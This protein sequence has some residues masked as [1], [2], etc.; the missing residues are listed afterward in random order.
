MLIVS[1]DLARAIYVMAMILY[2]V[3]VTEQSD[4]LLFWAKKW[5]RLFVPCMI[6]GVASCAKMGGQ[7]GEKEDI[8]H[9]YSALIPRFHFVE[10]LP[11]EDRDVVREALL[12]NMPELPWERNND[13]VLIL[14]GTNFSDPIQM[15]RIHYSPTT[16]VDELARLETRRAELEGEL[17]ELTLLPIEA[18]QANMKLKNVLDVSETKISPFYRRITG[19]WT[20]LFLRHKIYLTDFTVGTG[21]QTG[22]ANRSAYGIDFR[23]FISLDDSLTIVPVFEL[24]KDDIFII[25][26][27]LAQEKPLQIQC[28]NP[29]QTANSWT[30]PQLEQVKHHFGRINC[31]GKCYISY[32]VNHEQKLTHQ[33]INAFIASKSKG[34]TGFDYRKHTITDDGE[35]YIIEIRLYV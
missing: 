8:C 35:L 18:I 5:V 19:L 16:E 23:K 26:D 10:T 30:H 15:P 27:I 22:P 17:P 25:D 29:P 24:T 12:E 6:V 21:P 28:A 1:L 20:S 32:R 31:A 4:P 3:N 9:I 13:L 33:V 34:A 14:E 2:D 7:P 11:Y